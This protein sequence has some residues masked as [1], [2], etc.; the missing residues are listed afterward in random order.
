MQSSD[1]AQRTTKLAEVLADRWFTA[2]ELAA[3]GLDRGMV[4]QLLFM[5][6]VADEQLVCH[7]Q[8]NR[9]N[10]W[11]LLDGVNPVDFASLLLTQDAWE[12]VQ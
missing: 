10:K 8:V 11:H 5:A 1:S 9:K 4:G 7:R 2:D 12:R 6:M 3:C